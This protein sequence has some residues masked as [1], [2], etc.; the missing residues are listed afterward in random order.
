MIAVDVK[1][2]VL[3]IRNEQR[4]NNAPEALGYTK[5]FTGVHNMKTSCERLVFG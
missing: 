2:A 4:T 1:S 3:A 5:Y